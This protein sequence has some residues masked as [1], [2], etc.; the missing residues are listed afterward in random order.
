MF[1]ITV[2]MKRLIYGGVLVEVMMKRR[3]WQSLIGVLF[4]GAL[5]GYMWGGGN[6]AGSQVGDTMVY[7][8]RGEIV[9]V[10]NEDM[11]QS[12]VANIGF[13]RLRVKILRGDFK[14]QTVDATNQLNG[15][16][17]L[18]NVYESE[19]RMVL[20]IQVKDGQI[21]DAKAVD[22]YRQ[23]WILGLFLAFVIFLLIYAGF[24]GLKA[25]LSFVLS[26]TIL[27]QVLV[28][29]LLAGSNPMVLTVLTVVL[30]SAVIIFLVAGFTRKGLSAF[31]GTVAGLMVTLVLTL[32][33]GE[34]V[35][36]YGMTQPYVQQLI[37]SG[38][39]DLDI[40]QIFY[41]AIILGASGAAMDIAMDI[42]ASMDE[43][44]QKKPEIQMTEL[45]E[46]GFTIGRHVI[47]T[48]ATTLLLA[49]SG[50]YLT[51][52][53]LFQVKDSSFMRIMNLKIVAAEITRTLI[54]SIG[55]VM[56]APIT[57]IIAGF[58]I[59]G[60]TRSTTVGSEQGKLETD[61]E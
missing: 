43:I 32:L 4:L 42:A 1:V 56:V 49:Y 17:D 8:V 52:L 40:R 21:N 55:L 23:P 44:K 29:G 15:Q 18:D 41:A 3:L 47:G 30:L 20:A 19:D 2:G 54:G 58:I 38:Y 13:Q 31:L 14:G 27:W 24:I 51:L 5:L 12:G 34:Y 45:I 22:M 60:V 35:H 26:L 7:E 11:I 6:D 39:Y 59:S 28:K 16:M 53:M 36:L 46:S 25:L 50:G 57:A 37:F 9:H 10:D 61:V 48:M 33:F